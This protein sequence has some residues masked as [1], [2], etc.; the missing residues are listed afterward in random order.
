MQAMNKEQ[1]LRQ[2]LFGAR[3]AASRDRAGLSQRALA[4][5]VGLTQAAITAYERGVRIPRWPDL[6]ALADVL[7]V[8]ASWLIAPLV[9]PHVQRRE[10]GPPGVP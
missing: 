1:R 8:D 5:E 4:A 6:R 9:D 2:E 3:L 10:D 7:D